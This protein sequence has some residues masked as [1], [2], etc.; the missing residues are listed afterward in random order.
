MKATIFAVLFTFSTAGAMITEAEARPNRR[1]YKK[2]A[3]PRA[4]NHRSR[5]RTRAP[6]A[7]RTRQPVRRVRQPARRVRQP[8]R[9][10]YRQPARSH[11]RQPARSYHR[12]PARSHYRQPVRR[13][14]RQPVRRYYLQPVRTVSLINSNG[15]SIRVAV[16]AGNSSIC[17]A[18]PLQGRQYLA[19]GTSLTVSTRGSYVCYRQLPTRFS[20]GSGWYRAVITA[21]FT[22]LSF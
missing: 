12:Q 18:N 15:Y 14:Y 8:A 11:Y 6:R 19:P 10:H 22:R 17:S 5:V 7:V 9:S 13:Y 4:S 16:R 2:A 20:A 3:N 1:S 21:R